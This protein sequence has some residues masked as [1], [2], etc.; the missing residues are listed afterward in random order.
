MTF[1]F[2]FVFGGIVGATFTLMF[3]SQDLATRRRGT[4]IAEVTDSGKVAELE[5]EIERLESE[6]DEE[7][8]LLRA[9]EI[10]SSSPLAEFTRR[11]RVLMEQRKSRIL[12]VIVK[13]EDEGVTSADVAQL[14]SLSRRSARRYLSEL[15]GAGAIVQTATS[16]PLTRYVRAHP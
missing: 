12:S 15:V 10:E 4:V 6:I 13:K 8:G 5:N 11:M 14:L 2:A 1:L 9:C 7:R 16:G 3:T